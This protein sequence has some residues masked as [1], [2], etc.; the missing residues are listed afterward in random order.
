MSHNLKRGGIGHCTESIP[1]NETPRKINGNTLTLRSAAAVRPQHVTAPPYCV[2]LIACARYSP[3]TVSTAPA[4]C[5]LSMGRSLFSNSSSR[6]ITLLAP[7]V[8]KNDSCSFFPVHATT[9]KPA[10]ANRATATEPTPPVAPV[11]RIS[12]LSGVTPCSTKPCNDSP[13]VKPAVPMIIDSLNVSP[14]GLATAHSLG[15][16]MYSPK[17]PAVFMPRSNP[18]TITSSP[19]LK[20]LSPHDTTVPAASIPGV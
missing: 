14:F 16:L 17:P 1:S 11:T 6:V 12:P 20:R 9:E 15:I 18:V 2:A 5:S 13:A 7:S 10:L 8:F 4:N 3:P 19:S